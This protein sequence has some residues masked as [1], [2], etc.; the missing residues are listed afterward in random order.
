MPREGAAQVVIALLLVAA[1]LSPLAVSVGEDGRVVAGPADTS[2]VP[3]EVAPDP[4]FLEW[5]GPG[6]ERPTQTEVDTAPSAHVDDEVEV[7]AKIRENAEVPDRVQRQ[8][9][10][11]YTREGARRL[12]GT[13]PL[14]AVRELS[15]EPGIEGVRIKADPGMD[16]GTGRRSPGLDDIGATELHDR[17]VDGE[18]VVV[19]V[20]DSGF[21]LSHP[22]IANNVG[23]YNSFSGTSSPQHGTAVASVVADT[24]PAAELHLAAIGPS[25]SVEEYRAAVTWL[26][27]SGADV[28]VDAGSYFGQPG[29]GSGTIAAVASNA[30]E[31][32]AFVTSAGN[33][34]E[35]HW[36]STHYPSNDSK[37]VDVTPDAEGNHLGVGERVEGRIEL[38]LTWNGTGDYDLYLMRDTRGGDMAVASSAWESENEGAREQL[39]AVVPEGRYYVAIHPNESNPPAGPTSLELFSN[40]DLDY[41]TPEGSITAPASAEGVVAVGAYANGSVESFSSRGPLDDD[42]RG[43]DVVAPDGVR[44]DGVEAVGGTSFAAPYVAGTV[45]LLKAEF[46][47]LSTEEIEAIVRLSAVD[48]AAD[49]PD[50][51]TG[52][53]LVDAEAAY[54]TAL[55]TTDDADDSGDDSDD[56]TENGEDDGSSS[57]ERPGH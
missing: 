15:E 54:E 21:Q 20:I 40:R 57:P 23:A 55:S 24:A 37:Y 42:R 3:A 17:E 9:G 6:E 49:G 10:D 12:A 16:D 41:R 56:D 19:G 43:V 4:G 53:G 35:R 29:D 38:G 26:R 44:V 34:A 25:T 13:V 36:S 18:G 48:V 14:T 8:Y 47:D 33:Y 27:E 30:S 28:I 32:V 2:D 45:A 22:S 50:P 31:D 11:V 52:H 39:S 7:V 1:A 46:P 5:E 51:T